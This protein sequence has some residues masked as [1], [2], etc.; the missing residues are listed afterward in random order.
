M[1]K[2][3][4]FLVL[5]QKGTNN[6][7]KM[8]M[9]A[10]VPV[11]RFCAW[12]VPGRCLRF[13]GVLRLDMETTTAFKLYGNAPDI[14]ED[15]MISTYLKYDS[16]SK[17]SRLPSFSLRGDVVVHLICSSSPLTDLQGAGRRHNVRHS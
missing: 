11:L 16:A 3:G 12:W 5:L 17:V 9:W 6:M 8:H 7:H 10:H 2:D 14:V 4:N 1:F 15:E 13:R